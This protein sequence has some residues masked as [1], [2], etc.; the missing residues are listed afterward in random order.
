RE[1]ENA[2]KANADGEA[3]K[4]KTNTTGE[5][6]VT[7]RAVKGSRCSVEL[8]VNVPEAIVSDPAIVKVKFIGASTIELDLLQTGNTRIKLKQNDGHDINIDL[9][10]VDELT[11]GRLLPKKAK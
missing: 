11:E 6:P 4:G 2:P 3:L 9:S 5:N 1:R 7:I 10:V 8:P